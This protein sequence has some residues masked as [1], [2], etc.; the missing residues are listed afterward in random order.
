MATQ[1]FNP[2]IPQ[3]RDWGAAWRALRRLLAD[4]NDTVQVFHIMRALNGGNSQRGYHR[5]LQTPDGGRLAYER[6]E[7]AARFADRTWI[8]SF[9]E[10]TVGAAYRAFLDRTGYSADGLVEVS[11]TD[12]DYPRDL[13]HPYAWYGRRERDVHDIWH[14]LTGYQADEPLGE[15]C[16][17]AFSY[18]QTKGLGWAF[19]AGGAAAKSLKITRSRAFARAVAEGYRNGRRAAWLPAEDYLRLMAEPIAEARAR[20][21]IPEPHLYRAAQDQLRTIGKTGI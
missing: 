15:A 8:D 20:L 1:S 9:P 18:A 7:L 10:G 13:E 5:L 11:V 14:I 17:V 21:R 4:G 6:A 3:R 19:I 12:T 16:L 2:A